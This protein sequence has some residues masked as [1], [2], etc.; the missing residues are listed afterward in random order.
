MP[1][2][3]RNTPWRQGSLLTVETAKA[4]NVLHPED[5]DGSV[6]IVATHNCDLAQLPDKEPY[7]EVIVGRKIHKLDGNNTYAKSA[8]TLN[9]KFEGNEP[10]LAE[11]VI[12]N[13]RFIQ[14]TSLTGYQP[15]ID[16]YLS[17]SEFS[18]FQIWLASRYR[19]AA[20]PDEFERRMKDSGIA[21]KIAKIAKQHGEKITAIF[22]DVD[23]GEEIT[24]STPTD[25]YLLDIILLY[26]TEPD[27][28]SAE[29]TANRAKA[30]IEQ[31]FKEKLYQEQSE[32]WQDIELRDVDVVSEEALTYRQSTLLRKWNLDYLSLRT[33]PQQS[34]LAE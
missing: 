9:L 33:N 20:F 32:T 31:A 24:H 19:R 14:K 26:E 15:N 12:T 10:L 27:A 30:S 18:T 11:F 34:V 29:D 25:T 16:F 17:H 2:W 5:P 21:S 28:T 4:V 3:T 22:F 7:V 1:N 6:V 8:R 23:E 13:K